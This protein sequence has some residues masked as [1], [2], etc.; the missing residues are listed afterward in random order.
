MAHSKR[1]LFWAP[2]ALSLAYIAFLSLFALDV[3]GEGFGFWKTLLALV[4][5]LAPS[6]VL[7]G[8]LALAWRREWLGAL[9]FTTVGLGFGLMA[10]SRHLPAITKLIWILTIPGPALV[11]AALFLAGWLQREKAHAARPESRNV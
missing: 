11:V 2:R 1:V 10:L 7:L 3:F 5:H 6:F 8:I 9:L 4:I